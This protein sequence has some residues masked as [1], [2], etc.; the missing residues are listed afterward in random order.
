MFIDT[1]SVIDIVHARLV[2]DL[3]FIQ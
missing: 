3:A 1:V 2:R